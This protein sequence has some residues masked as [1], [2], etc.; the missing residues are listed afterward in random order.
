MS[1]DSL[2]QTMLDGI[3]D[4]YQKTVGFPTWDLTRGFA[5]GAAQLEAAIRAEAAKLDVTNLTGGDLTRFAA[6]Y[7]GIDRRAATHAAGTLTV[8][9]NGTVE[10]GALFASAGGVQFA[11]RRAVPVRGT[12]E[13]PVQAVLAGPGGN[14]PPGTVTEIP[15]TIP[16]IVSA[17]NQEAM[18]GG[19]AEEDDETL[20]ARY[21]TAVREPP[22]SGNRA[23]YKSWAFEVAG[24]G[25]V[26]TF[27]LARGDWTVDVVIVDD[28]HQPADRALVARVQAH[29]DPD[30]T[31]LGD[32]CAPIGAHCYVESAAALPVTV[33]AQLTLLD[34][35]DPDTVRDAARQALADY[36]ADLPFDDTAAAYVSH[37]QAG[38]LLL[39]V[40]GVLDYTALTL[41]GTAANLPVGARQV[42]VLGE[43]ALDVL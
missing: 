37:A 31:G 32:G 35:A 27:P 5:L 13:V 23:H 28:A 22:T 12:A 3:P 7:R 6:Q 36:L 30:S 15:V 24:V 43:V 33:A 10:A 2:H 25:G 41:N 34:T 19:Y 14:L 9:G 1:A 21:Y 4:S 8:T 16:G 18:T 26:K 39:D 17:V 42:A 29:I 38:A 11:A 20:R 40:P